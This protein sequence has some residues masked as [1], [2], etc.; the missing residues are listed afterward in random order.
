LRKPRRWDA[1]ADQSRRGRRRAGDAR[2]RRPRAVRRRSKRRNARPGRFGDERSCSSAT[3]RGRATSSFRSCGRARNDL[4]L[5]RARV[6]D[7]RRQ[8]DRGG[9]PSTALTRSARANGRRRVAPR[10]GRLRQRR[11]VEFLLDESNAFYFLEMNAAQVE[12]PVTNSSTTSILRA[13]T[14][15]DRRASGS[16]SPR[17][18]SCARLDRGRINAET[19]PTS[20][21]RRPEDLALEPPAGPGLRP[22]RVRPEEGSRSTTI[23]LLAKLIAFGSD[24]DA[25]GAARFRLRSFE[26]GGVQTNIG[27]LAKI[28]AE[29]ISAR[30]TTTAYSASSGTRAAPRTDDIVAL[31]MPRCWRRAS[32]ARRKCRIPFAS[33]RWKAGLA[34]HRVTGG[35]A[36]RWL[37]AGDGGGISFPRTRASNRR[38]GRVT[39]VQTASRSASPAAPPLRPASPQRRRGAWAYSPMREDSSRWRETGPMHCRTRLARVLEAMKMEHRI[40]DARRRR[41]SVRSRGDSSPPARLSGD[42]RERPDASLSTNQGWLESSTGSRRSSSSPATTTRRRMVDLSDGRAEAG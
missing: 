11:N 39:V 23:R 37:L 24:R 29:P 33:P 26:I 4:A 13:L 3:S 6:L 27:L 28:F 34:R 2:R 5:R 12:H 38:R 10:S 7:Q 17:R 1:A 8:K 22:M 35:D 18:T 16:N 25:R 41:Q 30:Q 42:L 21:S 36:D 14:T 32:L 15:R 9:A 31:A 19:R 20:T 40:K